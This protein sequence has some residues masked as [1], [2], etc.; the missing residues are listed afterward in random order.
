MEIAYNPIINS[1]ANYAQKD[2]D[3]VGF[4]LYHPGSNNSSQIQLTSLSFEVLD[5]WD[6]NIIISDIFDRVK[7]RRQQLVVADQSNLLDTTVVQLQLNSPITLNPG[8]ID[9]IVVMANIKNSSTLN[10]FKLRIADSTSFVVRDISSGANITVIADTNSLVTSNLF[11]VITSTTNL[12]I[13]AESPKIC[14]NKILPTTVITG[15]D[16]LELESFTLGYPYSSLYSPVILKSV[17]VYVLDS[18]EKPLDPTKLFDRIGYKLN[19]S[20]SVQ[21]QPFIQ[22]SS[23]AALFQFGTDGIILNPED[24][25][26]LTLI[27]DIEAD[28]PYDHFR[29][30]INESSSFNFVDQTDSTMLPKLLFAENC[31]Q[32]FPIQ[33]IVSSIISP[34]GRPLIE[35]S[36]PQVKNV[37]VGQQNI[38]IFSTTLNYDQETMQGDLLFTYLEGSITKRLSNTY[39]SYS[40]NDI[41]TNM[42]LLVNG[43]EVVAD[44]IFSYD[45]LFLFVDT[46]MSIANGD[47][48]DIK[49]LADLKNDAPSGNYRIKFT[50]STFLGI[51]DLQ[52]ATK[53]YP[54]LLSGSYPILSTE[55]SLTEANLKESFSNYPNPFGV[56]SE[57]TTI[58]FVLSENGLVNIELFTLTGKSVLH[59]VNNDN[60]IAGVYDSDIWVGK[61][62]KGQAVV[63]GTYFCRITVK[64]ASGK[65]ETELRKISVIR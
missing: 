31:N 61:N 32:I 65:E 47:I 30:I 49:V 12:K 1:S 38:P 42:R 33:T 23:G 3:L 44:S 4:T 27:G 53:V 25:V 28:V 58:T 41:F 2:F 54:I 10:T 36:A 63:P 55:L 22:L 9:S 26:V 50:D 5:E 52:L 15:K 6:N 21:Y 35:I 16:S 40:G 57:E 43:M 20:S 39:V 7:I 62:N 37:F 51:E 46:G 18:L 48:I 29:L 8:E 14:Y 13:A 45:S 64:Y 59:L 24:S 60:R 11:P 19:S 17:I 56:E 34:A